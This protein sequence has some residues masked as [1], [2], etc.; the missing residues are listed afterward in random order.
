MSTV[1]ILFLERCKQTQ[2]SFCCFILGNCKKHIF[3]KLAFFFFTPKFSWDGPTMVNLWP[4]WSITWEDVI[5]SI[6]SS[7]RFAWW[8]LEL[9]DLFSTQR[10]K[11]MWQFT[12]S[13]FNLQIKENIDENNKLV[14]CTA[15]AQSYTSASPRAQARTHT[16]LKLIRGP[17]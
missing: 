6:L 3:V 10:E 7:P 17:F 1:E 12:V 2:L 9:R 13:I 16:F 11:F 5:F 8:S 15:W 4:L 14:I